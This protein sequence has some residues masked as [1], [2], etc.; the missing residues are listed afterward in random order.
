MAG[1]RKPRRFG[2]GSDKRV[3]DPLRT[4][5]AEKGPYR[6]RQAGVIVSLAFG[7]CRLPNDAGL[8]FKVL[9]RNTAQ[10]R[11]KIREFWGLVREV[12]TGSHIPPPFL[13][14]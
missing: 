11:S 5:A 14:R 13:W 6:S 9:G 8:I 3:F 10:V 4:K 12:V 7:A 2:P 1:L